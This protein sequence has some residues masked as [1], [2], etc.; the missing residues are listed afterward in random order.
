MGLTATG[1]A[2]HGA[3]VAPVQQYDVERTWHCLRDQIAGEGEH[4]CHALFVLKCPIDTMATGTTTPIQFH[5]M[6]IFW[7]HLHI[8]SPLTRKLLDKLENY[9]TTMMVVYAG[10][11]IR[12]GNELR[13]IRRV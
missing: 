9:P 11:A 13:I 4:G 5:I 7:C 2:T 1:R 6:R 8:A 10:I 12:I 3:E